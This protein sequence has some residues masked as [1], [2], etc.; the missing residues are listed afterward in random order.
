MLCVPKL[1]TSTICPMCVVF[2]GAEHQP[3]VSCVMCCYAPNIHHLSHVCCVARRW[4]STICLLCSVLLRSKHPPFV[5][6]VF[7]CYAPNIYRLSHVCCVALR[8][9]SSIYPMCEALKT[10]AICPMCVYVA[11]QWTSAIH[12]RGIVLLC[13]KHLPLFRHVISHVSCGNFT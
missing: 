4:T 2:L 10:S 11:T 6:L 13:A 9:T 5:P 8:Q 3:F 1:Q 12:P 7:C